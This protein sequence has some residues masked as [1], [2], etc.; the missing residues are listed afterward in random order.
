[1]DGLGAGSAFPLVI[2]NEFAGSDFAAYVGAR[3]DDIESALAE[4]GALLFRG[5]HVGGHAGFERA[6][7][8]LTP[9]LKA[10]VG[11]GSPR[12]HVGGSV[13]TSTEYP[14]SAGIPLHCEAT[15][16][17]AIPTRLWFYCRTPSTEGGETPIGDMC[18]VERA[19]AP[20]FVERVKRDGVLYV[21]NLHAGEGFGKSWQQTYETDDR[22]TV[23]AHLNGEGSVFEWC[24]DGG[25]RVFMRGPAVRRHSKTGEDI[26]NN[27]LVNWHPAHL[28]GDAYRR[29]LRVYGE[30]VN[31]PKCA[32]YGDGSPIDAAD[33]VRAAEALSAI[34]VVFAWRAED[35]LLIDNERISHGRRPFRGERAVF[36]AMA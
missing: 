11:G 12:T 29:L 28:G 24:P 26:W 1:M 35:V 4:H 7:R 30:E 15:Y 3:S 20:E 17:P 23:E 18:G 33:V 8:A 22:A 31:F 2:D 16:L 21:S 9:A 14:A 10:Y 32:F 25:L 13:Y 5:A 19:L 27:Q 36:V 34:E 6:A